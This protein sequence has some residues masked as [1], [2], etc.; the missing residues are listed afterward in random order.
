MVEHPQWQIIKYFYH[1]PA[2]APILGSSIGAKWD[3]MGIFSFC[4]R[5]Q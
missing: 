5:Y 4:L 3:Y 1:V 2:L